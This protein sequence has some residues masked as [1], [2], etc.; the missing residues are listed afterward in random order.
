MG[1]RR[2][3]YGVVVIGATAVLGGPASAQGGRGQVQPL[4]PALTDCT[5]LA[6]A[7]RT[8]AAND[9]RLRD[10]PN[11][12]R[13]REANHAVSQPTA[14]FMGDSIT[15]IWQQP[16]FGD[17]FENPAYVDRGI[18]GQTTPQ[19]L[20][21][22]RADVINLHP[23]VVVILGGTNDIAGN[24]GPMTDEEIEGNLQSMAE[25]ADAA[26]I[27]VVLSSL[28][29]VAAYHTNPNAAPQTSQRPMARIHAINDW[30]KQYAAA[31]HHVYLD[32]FSAMVDTQGLLRADLSA[33]DL[34]P[35][36]AGFALMAPLA[37]AAVEQALR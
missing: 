7:V 21:R 36:A 1:V 28:T 35:T 22:F 24:T 13:Y 37:K 25:L 27:K 3:A 9:A 15:D 16:R 33:D 12:A 18:G 4:P 17:F 6:S 19:M 29:P 5:S 30:M 34:H 26:G 31:H 32:Y 11:L 20:L 2:M 8:V 14:V 10:W 23:K